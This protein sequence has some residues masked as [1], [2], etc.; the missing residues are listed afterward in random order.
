[1]QVGVQ[2]VVAIAAVAVLCVVHGLGLLAAT[3][4]FPLRD[5]DL[6]RRS[7]EPGSFYLLP[8]LGV[9]LFA[10]HAIEIAL[11]AALYQALGCFSTFEAAL[12]VSAGRYTTTGNAQQV[13][14]VAWR[15][16]GE[17]EALIGLLLIG[18]SIAFL[19]QK[20]RILRE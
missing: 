8:A 16:L 15:L 4:L 5:E 19:T 12:Y 10:I 7:L 17:A 13:L 11:F 14:P 1:M 9:S 3:R 20:I 6:R 2:L 18:W